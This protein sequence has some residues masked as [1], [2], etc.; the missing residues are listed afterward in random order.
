MQPI[1]GAVLAMA[2]AVAMQWLSLFILKSLAV[3]FLLYSLL[4][5]IAVPLIDMAAFR[6]IGGAGVL[7]R[8]GLKP[9]ARRDIIAGLAIGAVLGASI[10]AAFAFL[11]RNFLRGGDARGVVRSW[12]VPDNGLAALY[13]GALVLNGAIEEIF[14]RGYLHERLA[15]I[16][17]RWLAVSLPALVFGSQHI[18]VMSALVRDPLGLTL[19]MCGIIGAGLFWGFLRERLRGL[20]ASLLSHALVAIAYLSVLY[21]FVSS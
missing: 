4:A 12:G 9:I 11:G 14:W 20:W 3:S 6:R 10:W 8:L 16:R 15:G 17:R 13:L 5:C 18:F 21:V 1:L 2:F 19:A 7:E